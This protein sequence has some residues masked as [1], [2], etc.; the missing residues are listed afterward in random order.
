[1]ALIE[2]L[3]HL[4]SES[5]DRHIAVH[6]F[7]AAATEV[8]AGEVTRQQMKNFYDMTSEDETDFDAI[9]NTLVGGNSQRALRLQRI[10]AVFILA[11]TL[12]DEPVPGYDTPSAV[13][14]KLGI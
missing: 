5:D 3:M 2:R 4:D 1:M 9:A 7:F 14:A 11:E 6:Q 10:H 13:R 8:N 12:Q